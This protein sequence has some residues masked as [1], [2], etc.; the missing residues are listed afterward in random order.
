MDASGLKIIDSD[1]RDSSNSQRWVLDGV[2]ATGYDRPQQTTWE[3]RQDGHTEHKRQV[4]QG[5]ALH[6]LAVPAHNGTHLQ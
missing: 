2:A 3:E 5:S 1:P 6:G 4:A